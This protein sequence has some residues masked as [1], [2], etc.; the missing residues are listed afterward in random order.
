MVKARL[1]CSLLCSVVLLSASLAIHFSTNHWKY[2][3]E[4]FCE[5]NARQQI[6]NSVGMNE[7]VLS[8]SLN[9]FPLQ[10]RKK[11]AERNLIGQARKLKKIKQ[12]K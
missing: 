3:S 9:F 7:F 12:P 10:L 2:L 8:L 4:N 11:F 5:N 1:A 6:T